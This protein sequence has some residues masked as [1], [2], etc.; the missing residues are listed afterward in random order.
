MSALPSIERPA[1]LAFDQLRTLFPELDE[2]AGCPQ[3]PEFHGEGDVATHTAMVL[4]ALAEDPRFWALDSD[5]RS[6]VATAAALHDIGKPATTRIENGRIRQPGHARRGEILTRVQLWR[7]GVPAGPRERIANLVRF[8]LQPFH[9]LDR[10]RPTER[11]FHASWA[12]HGME[13]LLLLARADAAG[14]ISA[15]RDELIERVELAR[16]LAEEHATVD[17]PFDFAS[18]HS[19]VQWF[20]RPER[21]PRHELHDDTEFEVILMSG[22]PASGKDHWVAQHRPE[23]PVVSL[24]QLRVELGIAPT[25][26]QGPIRQAAKE[27]ARVHLRASQPFVWNATN[28]S[29]RVRRQCLDLFLAYGA[30]VHIV[31]IEAPPEVIEQR[32]KGRSRPV[33]EA[34]IDRMM[35]N[36]EAPDLTEA[37]RVTFVDNGG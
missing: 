23:L 3:E 26:N 11:L 31:A 2:L 9:L 18:D 24:D 5:T 33:P 8:H 22:L 28:L 16:L 30:R 32:N 13:T 17:A 1:D 27:R 6:I 37:H 10:D 20:R 29:R 35:T 25:Q 12:C 21:D 7:S 34:A 15:T 14:R 36:W 19:R 4:D